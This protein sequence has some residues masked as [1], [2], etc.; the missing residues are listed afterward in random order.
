MA[1]IYRKSSAY[2]PLSDATYMSPNMKRYFQN[3]LYNELEGLIEEE[4]ALS[5][6]LRENTKQ[7]PDFVDQSCIEELRFKC[8]AYQEHEAHLRHEVEAALQRLADGSYG[9]CAET[10]KPIGVERLIAAPYALYCFEV[11]AAKEGY[12]QRRWG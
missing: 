1:V 2:S 8:H 4:R 11:Q 3:K 10:G 7:E 6:S 12:R 5:L 9:Y